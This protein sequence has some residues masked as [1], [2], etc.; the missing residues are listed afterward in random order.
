MYNTTV[1]SCAIT[2]LNSLTSFSKSDATTIKSQI[3]A[4][5]DDENED[6]DDDNNDDEDEDEISE[7]NN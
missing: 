4:D 6:N 7:V 5:E 2:W 1:T 3:V